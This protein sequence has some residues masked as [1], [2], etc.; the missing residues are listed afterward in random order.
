MLSFNDSKKSFKLEGNF[1]KTMTNY[2][3][4]VCHSNPRDQKPIYE[5]EKEMKFNIKKV[6]RKTPRDEPLIKLL[7][8][9][10]IMA[11][12]LKK[13][14]SSKPKTQNLKKSKTIFLPSHP[15]GICWIK[16]V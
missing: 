5:F 6:G 14:S 8:S 10:V 12:S 3:F 4:N 16:K 7:I 11:G 1:L 9:P 13:E 2:K 15:N